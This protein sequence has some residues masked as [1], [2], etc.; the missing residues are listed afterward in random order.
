MEKS[1]ILILILVILAAFGISFYL[2]LTSTSQEDIAGQAYSY[3]QQ[4]CIF[5][6]E[7]CGDSHPNMG[8]RLASTQE[9]RIKSLQQGCKG[10]ELQWISPNIDAVLCCK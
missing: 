6:E 5:C 8:G 3:S 7:Y 10:D 9:L 4:G 1:Q 2:T